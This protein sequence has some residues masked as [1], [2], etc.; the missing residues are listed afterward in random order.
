MAP[1]Q[2]N[3]SVVT[4]ASASERPVIPNGM[5][6]V[7]SPLTADL[8][9]LPPRGLAPLTEYECVAYSGDETSE[10][11][12]FTTEAAVQL[13]NSGFETFSN[14]ESD[15][16]YSFYDPA[17]PVPVLQ[18][19]WWGSGNKGSTTVGSKFAITKPDDTERLKENIH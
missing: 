19:K 4:T 18:T 14:A 5:R 6:S 17:S 3:R 10:I 12:R 13:P 1:C 7:E 11:V 8:F 9:R 15:K 2:R 16:Y